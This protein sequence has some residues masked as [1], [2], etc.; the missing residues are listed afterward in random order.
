VACSETLKAT[1]EAI[2]GA[3]TGKDDE[4]E[5]AMAAASP[6]NALAKLTDKVAAIAGAKSAAAAAMSEAS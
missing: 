6:G 1:D 3:I 2:E 5:H 4:T